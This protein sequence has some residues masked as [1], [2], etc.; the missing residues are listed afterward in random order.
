M[1]MGMSPSLLRHLVGFGVDA[2]VEERIPLVWCMH[3]LLFM[4][5]STLL[6][7]QVLLQEGLLFGVGRTGIVCQQTLLYNWQVIQVRVSFNHVAK[8]RDVIRTCSNDI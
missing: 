1:E 4:L 8:P 5:C 2:K 3:R 7:K 6:W